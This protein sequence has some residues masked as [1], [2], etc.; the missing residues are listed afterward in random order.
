MGGY[1]GFVWSA[2]VVTLVVLVGLLVASVLSLRAQE[3][4]LTALQHAA[5]PPS[6]EAGG[7]A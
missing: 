7:E 3:A 5:D 6:R 4:A 2:F 1:G